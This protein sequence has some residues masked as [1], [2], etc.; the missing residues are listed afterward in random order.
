MRY[1]KQEVISEQAFNVTCLFGVS[2]Q[3]KLL[4]MKFITYIYLAGWLVIGCATR[5]G[6]DTARSSNLMINQ[7][8]GEE[9]ELIIID[10]QFQSWVTTNAKPIHFY[11]LSYYETQNKKYVTAWNE[12][13]HTTGGRGPFGNYI[14]YRFSEN[15]GLELNYELYWYFKYIESIYG[16]RYNFPY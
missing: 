1:V 12:L 10:P 2:K 4:V 8:E 14:D 5:S 13:F 16:R 7:E 9:H 6:L 15:Y 11:T 3:I